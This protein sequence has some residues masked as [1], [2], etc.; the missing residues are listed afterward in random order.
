MDPID[1]RSSGGDGNT[2]HPP[3]KKQDS[4]ALQWAWTAFTEETEVGL[5]ARLDPECQKFRFQRERC[6]ETGREHYQGQ[7]TLKK[8]QRLTAIAK[9]LPRGTHLE[10]TRNTEAS[11]AYAGKEESRVAGPW[12]KGY[13]AP[14]RLI[15]VL[16][17][18]Q[19][20]VVEIV[21]TP[22]DDRTIHW[23]WDRSGLSGKTALCKLLCARYGAVHVASGKA[24]DLLTFVAKQIVEAKKEVLLVTMLLPKETDPATIRYGA[25]ESLKDGLWFSGKYEGAQVNINPPHVF[26]F[27]NQPPAVEKLSRDRWHIVELGGG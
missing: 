16:R 20:E 21:K 4:P 26:V 3:A 10:K 14:L 7:M 12:E 15:S 11:E 1:P 2:S 24:S 5:I 13:P 19:A 17:P 25:L 23:Y 8:K 22:P 27:A 18:W 6:P 9:W